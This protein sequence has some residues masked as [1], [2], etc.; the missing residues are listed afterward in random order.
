MSGEYYYIDVIL[1]Q[2]I[3]Q[4]VK[5][6]RTEYDPEQ[7]DMRFADTYRADF[8][9]FCYRHYGIGYAIIFDVDYFST[10]FGGEFEV[11]DQV[12][13]QCQGYFVRVLFGRLHI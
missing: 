12:A 13:L 10:Q 6:S 9:L 11:I 4:L 8:F 3:E 7:V 2:F 1:G 5:H